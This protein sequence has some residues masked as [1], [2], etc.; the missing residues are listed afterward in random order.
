MSMLEAFVTTS[1]AARILSINPKSAGALVRQGKIPAE[2]I[3]NRW[4]IPRAAVMELAKG[5]VPKR[6]RP[7]KKRKYIKRSPVWFNNR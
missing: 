5:Y 2:K 4:L 3:A 7:R 1:D 6:G